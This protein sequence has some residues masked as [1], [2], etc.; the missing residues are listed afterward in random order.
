MA[1]AA[2]GHY[3][4]LRRTQLVSRHVVSA[5]SLADADNQGGARSDGVL[6]PVKRHDADG[7]RGAVVRVAAGQR[8]GGHVGIWCEGQG[9]VTSPPIRPEAAVSAGLAVGCGTVVGTVAA[10]FAAREIVR[11]TADRHRL[12]EWGREWERVEPRWTGRAV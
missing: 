5:E 6:V 9:R 7:R 12:V 11:I 2:Y 1:N 10:A 8:E 4:E 3:A